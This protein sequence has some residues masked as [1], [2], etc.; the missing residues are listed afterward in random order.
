M[1]PRNKD[2]VKRQPPMTSTAHR[3]TFKMNTVMSFI[4]DDALRLEIWVMLPTDL[5]ESKENEP[6]L[7]LM[8][9]NLRKTP[10]KE[11][12]AEKRTASTLLQMFISDPEVCI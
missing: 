4:T 2:D 3:H 12:L 6:P 5:A 7:P 1:N 11:P 9:Q 8:A 10:R